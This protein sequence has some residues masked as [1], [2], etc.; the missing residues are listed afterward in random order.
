M[1]P[2]DAVRKTTQ[3]ATHETFDR[4]VERQARR[5][6]AAFDAGEFRGGF[7]VG[8][9]LEGYAVDDDGRLTAV[10][11][12]L[13]GSVAERELGRHNAELNTPASPFDEEGLDA[14]ADALEERTADL[15]AAFQAAACR[16]VTDG[17][18][19]IPPESGT[20]S[21]LS[22]RE[23][24]DGVALAKNLA[25]AGRYHALDAD[26]T[27]SGPVE[28]D[29]PGC[30][31]TFP[32]IL[33]ESLATS[34]QVHLQVPTPRFPEYFA[35]ALR[36]AGPVLA[37]AANSP[38]LPPD[39]YTDPDP[40]TVLSGPLELRV[41]VFE[42]INVQKPG[43]VR[44]PE[45]LE[46]PAD[47][48]ELVRDDRTC[49][50]YLREWETDA[51]REGFADRYWEFL[52][53]QGTCWRWIRPILGPDGPRLEY[54][55]LAAQPS[56]RDVAGFHALVVGL[57]H[58]VVATDHPLATLPWDAARD[59]LYAAVEDG[60][61]ADLAWITR[62]GERTNDPDVVYD[63]LF[64]LARRGLEDRGIGRAGNLIAPVERRWERRT[65][66]AT[67]K[68]DRARERLA[69]GSNLTEAIHD[70]QRTYIEHSGR[71]EPF[72]DWT[73]G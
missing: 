18:W 64:D 61:E 62:A 59:S 23:E 33:V 5:L 30:R 25:A 7:V 60:L 36:T 56:V 49:A 71:D 52:H 13:F 68:R 41:P 42:S 73:Q 11:E 34:M 46:V 27:A 22:D 31:R 20:V 2:V 3:T 57:V 17:M 66:P 67:W 37:L 8:L 35:V 24:R 39:L 6:R 65:T 63:E 50:P 16:L 32:T 47:L 19:T 72:V 53:K 21:Y 44:F 43:K 29:V 69:D 45:D 38:F 1:D 14:H 54:R 12:S 10:P 48:L 58:G 55:T 40:E 51:P 26:I 70:T 28:L 9:E 15:R 4:R